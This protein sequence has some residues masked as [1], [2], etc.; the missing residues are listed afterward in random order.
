M[1][2]RP[3]PTGPKAMTTMAE[4]QAVAAHLNEVMDAL[5]TV[6]EQETDL[7]RAGRI[8]AAAQLEQSKND[9]TRLYV[10]DT[11]ALNANKGFIEAHQP[12]LL[13]SLRQRHDNFHALL[14]INLTVLATAHAVA[15]SL[16]RGVSAELTKKSAP[17]IYGASGR[18][19]APRANTSVPIAMMRTL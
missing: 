13:K 5:L 3:V 4:A 7:V 15:E 10:A 19:S 2:A 9:L 18:A 11:L 16:V 14:Q 6:V 17:Q 1:A 12:A 8:A